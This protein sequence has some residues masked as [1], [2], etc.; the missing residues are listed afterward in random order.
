VCWLACADARRLFAE[1]S[2][3][4]HFVQGCTLLSLCLSD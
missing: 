4:L 1:V 2:A 3:Q